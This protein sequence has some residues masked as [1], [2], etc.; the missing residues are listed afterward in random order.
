[1]TRL[2]SL[3]MVLLVMS[4]AVQ[5]P[6]VI[7]SINFLQEPVD[8]QCVY[9][10]IRDTDGFSVTDSISS[11]GTADEISAFFN[12]S[13][14]VRVYVRDLENGTSEVS[15]FVRIDED[16]SPLDRRAA[17]FAVRRADDVIYRSCT[18]DGKSSSDDAAIILEPTEQ[19]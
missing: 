11:R 2:F 8:T 9:A 19:Q 15:A 13:L 14:P 5:K 7:S 18:L 16:A 3:P 10:A 6:D 17:S 1:M 12:K 4:C